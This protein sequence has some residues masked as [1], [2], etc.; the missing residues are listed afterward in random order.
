MVKT[1][2]FHWGGTGATPGRGTKTSHV[3]QTKIKEKKK[4]G[5]EEGKEGRREGNYPWPLFFLFPQKRGH[6]R[7]L[8]SSH[9]IYSDPS[10]QS[11]K[12]LKP[13]MI[14]WKPN[15]VDHF[16][17]F[18]IWP[19][20]ILEWIL[21]LFWKMISLTSWHRLLNFLLS[22]W[23]LLCTPEFSLSTHHLYL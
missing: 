6:I 18:L 1:L 12:L 17:L 14:N 11:Q 20:A 4:K 13:S 8:F 3:T 15:L 21:P 19:P 10:H 5:K 2:Q 22:L 23:P 16:K 7:S 9:P